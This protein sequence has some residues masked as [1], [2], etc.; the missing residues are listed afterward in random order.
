MTVSSTSASAVLPCTYT[1]MMTGLPDGGPA[2]AVSV[3]V[4]DTPAA[5]VLTPVFQPAGA[6]LVAGLPARGQPGGDAALPGLAGPQ[7][8]DEPLP[9]G[10]HQRVPGGELP[11]VARHGG[12]RDRVALL[13]RLPV[14]QLGLP[15]VQP[16]EPVAER[17]VVA[18]QAGRTADLLE[19]YVGGGVV[20]LGD[21]GVAEPGRGQPV[22]DVLGLPGDGGVGDH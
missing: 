7:P 11:Q 12:G 16:P 4:P 1:A 20:A 14:V 22:P 17:A 3:A 5:A 19:Q 6:R 21:G 2:I 8:A 13:A 9:V 10:G 15:A 18:G